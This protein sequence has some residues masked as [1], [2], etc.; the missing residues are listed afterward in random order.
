VVLDISFLLTLF[1]YNGVPR[2]GVFAKRINDGVN[3]YI[4]D[5]ISVVV[6]LVISY[7]FLG[8]W[9]RGERM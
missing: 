6:V 5:Q 3:F 4:S 7:S 2:C 9:K 1:L 8:V